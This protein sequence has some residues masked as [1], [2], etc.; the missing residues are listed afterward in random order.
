[1]HTEA[2]LFVCTLNDVMVISLS[3]IYS[4]RIGKILL[5]FILITGKF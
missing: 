3:L 1:M 5:E 4:R 2:K